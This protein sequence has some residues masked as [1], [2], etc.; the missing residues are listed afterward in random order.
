MSGK[1]SDAYIDRLMDGIEWGEDIDINDIPEMETV[2]GSLG[3]TINL[4]HE[5]V[6][7]NACTI[8][9]LQNL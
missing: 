5:G 2:V 4:G 3:K 7:I 9:N 1:E 8:S 6:D